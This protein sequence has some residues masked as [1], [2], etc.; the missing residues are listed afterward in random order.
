VKK[1]IK[2]LIIMLLILPLSSC[3]DSINLEESLI[4]Y[5][6]GVD[7]SQE[8]PNNYLFTIA[9]PTIIEEAPEKKSTF[10]TEAPSLGRGKSNLQQKV[11]RQL[12]YDNIK[13]VVF[14]EESAKQGILLHVDSM[15]RLPLFRGT[16]RF[17]V[18]KDRTV[19]LLKLEP[20]VSL[21]I[22]TFIFESIKQN[23]DATTVPIST[24]RNFSNQYYTIGI[25]PS[26]PFI[27]YGATKDE[28][29]IGCIA[30]FKEDKMIHH[31]SGNNSKAFML[32]KGEVNKGIYTSEYVLDESNNKDFISITFLGG[33]STIKTELIDSQL[34]I[35]QDISIR[36]DLGEY[37][38]QNQIFTEDK[39]KELEGYFAKEINKDLNDTLKILQNELKNDNIGYGKYV[40]A[41]HPDFFDKEDW[42]S[43]FTK[44]IIHVNSNVKIRNIGVTP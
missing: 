36:A 3:W 31:L 15:L 33:K 4:V 41:N 40:K 8:N 32:L 43:Q 42:N 30:L 7:I 5:A 12:S 39:I 9:F 38:P 35:F 29:N 25:E 13:V 22:S 23:H 26:M 18:V 20:P 24:L 11:Y 2:L 44:A 27:C 19:D 14:S 28:L 21:L 1:I 6:L 16:T 34:H 10:S 17:A 37:T